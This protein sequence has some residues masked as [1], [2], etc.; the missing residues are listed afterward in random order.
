[1]TKFLAM[2]LVTENKLNAYLN[3]KVK[4]YLK[5]GLKHTFEAFGIYD[6]NF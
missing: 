6:I 1:M 4:V 5:K 3:R 2:Y